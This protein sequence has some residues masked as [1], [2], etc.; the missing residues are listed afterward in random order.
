MLLYL[1]V[2]D[3]QSLYF[4]ADADEWAE[5][6]A[7]LVQQYQVKD[8]GPSSWILGM[9]IRRDRAARK[10][11][12]DQELYVTKA[13]EKYGL[14]QC[15]PVATPECISSDAREPSDTSSP[16]G[17]QVDK[18][19]FQEIV[20]TLL[21]AAI[22]TRLDIAHAVHQLT[23][24][25][26]DPQPSDMLAA[27]RILRYLAGSAKWCLQFG[28]RRGGDDE[29]L[30]QPLEVS[31]FADADWANDKADRRSVSGWVVQLDGDPIDWTSK[32][33]SIVAQSTCEA[34][35]YAEAAAI[36]EV[37]W[38]RGMLEELGLPLKSPSIVFGDNS[39]TQTISREGVKRKRTK[40][41]DVKYHFITECIERGI[42]DL[43][44]VPTE[45]QQADILTKAL[46]RAKFEVHREQLMSC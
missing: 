43:Q 21:Y 41:V 26:Q 20:G 35:L 27:R 30:H 45:Q 19:A 17:G 16:Q 40:H 29:Q 11:F 1:F 32:K 24:Q 42:I 7:M 37:L 3:F 28:G 12:L 8:L 9:A 25:M 22:S 46:D 38:L 33:Q 4:S 34:E 10:I 6:K 5:L 39:S 15:R 31:A 36:N 18:H 14:A 2:D 13:L 23:R 44:W